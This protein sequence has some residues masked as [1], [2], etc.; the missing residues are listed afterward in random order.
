MLSSSYLSMVKVR[1]LRRKVW[2]RILTPIERS[3]FNL[4]LK[5][6][7]KVRS[8]LLEGILRK[9]VDKLTEALEGKIYHLMRTIGT[10][11]AQKISATARSWGNR[12]AEKWAEDPFFIRFLAITYMNTP[13]IYRVNINDA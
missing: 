5:V 4:T 6:V 1:A 9:I 12:A 7:G 2:F 3:I 8:K 10:W 13:T 11:M